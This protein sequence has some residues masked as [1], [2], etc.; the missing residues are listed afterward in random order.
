M[1]ISMA[2]TDQN[3]ARFADGLAALTGGDG[4]HRFGLAV[5][6]GPDSLAMLL[7]AHAAL[8]GR[9]AAATVDHGLRP[10]SGAEAAFVGE[11]CAARG[12][13]HTVIL[14]DALRRGNVS[15]AAREARYNALDDWTRR[16]GLDWLLTAHHADD[17]LETMVMRLN[18]ASG[19]G[20]LA[21]VR[22]RRGRIIR[23][24]LGWRRTELMAIVQAAGIAPVDDPSNR[25]DRYDRARLR[26][27]LA[28]NEL[29]DAMAVTASASALADADAALDWMT[30]RLRGERL[31]QS[32]SFWFYDAHDL[33]HELKRRAL[34]D[35]LRVISPDLRPRG[36]AIERVL[37]ALHACKTMTIG[38]VRCDA[39]RD[40][41]AWAFSF[42]P[43][44]KGK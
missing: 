17:Q 8:P 38:A 29:L 9:I 10:A 11:L 5:S 30:R 26:K 41:M 3:V 19:V 35:C 23:P 15:D 12:I 16:D 32:A 42:A 14:L 7:L 36:T 34:I 39:V 24:L 33:P 18:R 20:G 21:G 37:T 43:P 1:A 25:D 40:G 13:P 2:H 28:T 22:A 31:K 6:G 44:R 4:A 27:V